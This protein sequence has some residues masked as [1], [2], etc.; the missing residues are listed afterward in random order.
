MPCEQG[1][2]HY[3][4]G[5]HLPADHP[6]RLA[7]LTRAGEIFAHIGALFELANV[8]AA[9]SRQPGIEPIRPAP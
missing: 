2:A 6:S 7:H 1:R 5:R 8:Q 3:Q 4:I 9:I